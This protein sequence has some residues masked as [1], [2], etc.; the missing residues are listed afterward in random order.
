MKVQSIML[1]SATTLADTFLQPKQARSRSNNT[2]KYH[3][4]MTGTQPTLSSLVLQRPQIPLFISC[5]SE[6]ESHNVHILLKLPYITSNH[7][8]LHT[9]FEGGIRISPEKKFSITNSITGYIRKSIK[10]TSCFP[11]FV[12][13]YNSTFQLKSILFRY[14]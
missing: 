6:G 8:E 13:C 2:S 3:L 10:K 4:S 14:V 1:I 7:R 9:F 12:F 11:I 5:F